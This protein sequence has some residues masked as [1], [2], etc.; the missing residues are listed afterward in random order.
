LYVAAVYGALLSLLL[1]GDAI[2]QLN[3]PGTADW[4][5]VIWTPLGLVF[6]S[7]VGF[8]AGRLAD[9][10]AKRRWFAACAFASF[11]FS[12]GFMLSGWAAFGLPTALFIV[13]AVRG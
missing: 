4:G 8:F 7:A 12:T 3:E 6:Y 10:R 9:S 1:L 13:L 2:S 5:A 11:A